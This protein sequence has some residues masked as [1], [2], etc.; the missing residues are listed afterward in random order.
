MVV[1]V[2]VACWKEL[3]VWWGFGEGFQAP[4]SGEPGA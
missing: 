4:A 2:G 1:G 3:V